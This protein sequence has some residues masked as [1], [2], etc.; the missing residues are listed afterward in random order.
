MTGLRLVVGVLV[1]ALVVAPCLGFAGGNVALHHLT[2]H[3]GPAKTSRTGSS[4]S[5]KTT[6]GVL[7]YGS[8]AIVLGIAGPV[9]VRDVVDAPSLASRP[10]F[11]PPRA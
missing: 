9:P 1:V 8:P 3:P 7:A 4:A 6:P 10:P 2:K 5:W 11:V